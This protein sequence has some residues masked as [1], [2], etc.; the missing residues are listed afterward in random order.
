[1]PALDGN[2]EPVDDGSEAPLL[3]MPP[4]IELVR[5]MLLEIF[6]RIGEAVGKASAR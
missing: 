1:M 4:E 2:G 5:K 3:P 6:T